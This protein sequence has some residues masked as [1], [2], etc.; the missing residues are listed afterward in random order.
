MARRILVHLS[1]LLV[2]ALV[3]L[4][5][6]WGLQTQLGLDPVFVVVSVVLAVFLSQVVAHVVVPLLAE[7]RDDSPDTPVIRGTE[8]W[9]WLKPANGIGAG[10]PLNKAC[11]RL[12]RGVEMDILLNNAS[13]SR[14]HAQL[15]KLEDG[16]LLE[17]LESRN[18]VFV[19]DERVKEQRL[20]NGDRV[21]VGEVNFIFVKVLQMG[22]RRTDAPGATLIEDDAGPRRRATDLSPAERL[23]VESQQAVRPFDRTAEAVPETPE[24]GDTQAE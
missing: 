15:R 23:Q 16:C 3:G 24:V 10:F 5:L 9:G 11:I 13:I 2:G 21:K 17:D 19:N 6:G 18:G 20:K 4:S 7:P 14:R 1:A 12:G 8:T 22:R